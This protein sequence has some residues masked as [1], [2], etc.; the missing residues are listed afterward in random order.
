MGAC[1]IIFFCA[2]PKFFATFFEKI[3]LLL[4]SFCFLCFCKTRGKLK[5]SIDST[6]F[7]L[8]S[9][10]LLFQIF[11][12]FLNKKIPIFI[13]KLQIRLMIRY[14]M[15]L[16]AWYAVFI[17]IT[18]FLLWKLQFCLLIHI[19]KCFSFSVLYAMVMR[20]FLPSGTL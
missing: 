16:L 17:K 18:F 5:R 13:I 1:Y 2:S 9:R 10:N 3:Y 8:F 14:K 12:W 20:L 11:F 6:I 19:L 15:I 7:L 4:F